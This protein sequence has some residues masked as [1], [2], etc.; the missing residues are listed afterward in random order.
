MEDNWPYMVSLEGN[1]SI[2]R[3]YVSPGTGKRIISTGDDVMGSD[4]CQVRR[5]DDRLIDDGM[6][7]ISSYNGWCSP[8]FCRWL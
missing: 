7:S 4:S 6:C 3:A 2:T 8:P 1:F 5:K